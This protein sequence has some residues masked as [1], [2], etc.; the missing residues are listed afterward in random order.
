MTPAIGAIFGGM[1]VQ[2]IGAGGVVPPSAPPRPA[3]VPS[4]AAWSVDTGEWE[5]APRDAE[6]RREGLV[7]AWRADGT[8]ASETGFRAG[9]REGAWRRF[10][11]DGSV[12]RQGLFAGGQ[13]HGVMI[14]H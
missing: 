9:E 8:L 14:A 12:A 4:D 5:L 10:H 7:R 2:D 3:T 13:A 11:P 1:S 6:G